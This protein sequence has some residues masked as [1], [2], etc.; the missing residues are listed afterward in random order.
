MKNGYYFEYDSTMQY[1]LVLLF[2]SLI[3]WYNAYNK[4]VDYTGQ[5]QEMYMT[6]PYTETLNLDSELWPI[7]DCMHDEG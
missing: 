2:S 1:I 4:Q 5:S 3:C 7:M 6:M